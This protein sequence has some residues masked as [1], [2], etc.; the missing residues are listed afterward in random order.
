MYASVSSILFYES[1]SG[2]IGLW[3]DNNLYAPHV[4]SETYLGFDQPTIKHRGYISVIWAYSDQEDR[5]IP[6]FSN[7][8]N[9]FIDSTNFWS[10]LG[11][12]IMGI[13]C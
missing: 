1:F 4:F 6:S 9:Y 13:R 7:N 5:K 10:V 12:N 8:T 3:V 11:L 2:M